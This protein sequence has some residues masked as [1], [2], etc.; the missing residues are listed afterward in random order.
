MFDCL[1]VVCVVLIYE[2]IVAVFVVYV[3]S[4]FDDVVC[5]GVGLDDFCGLFDFFVGD[6]V[7]VLVFF[8]WFVD[9]GY[10]F[11]IVLIFVYYVVFVELY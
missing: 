1:L 11:E 5:F 8:V 3:K 10:L 4:G 6:V 2:F 7:K 9:I